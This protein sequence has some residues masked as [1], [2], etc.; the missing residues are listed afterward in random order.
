MNYQEQSVCLEGSQIQS[1]QAS[2]LAV[3]GGLHF[4]SELREAI[5]GFDAG[6]GVEGPGPPSP[7]GKV[8]GAVQTVSW[9]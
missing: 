9:V 2:L 5:G 6:L 1:R 7:I 8:T 3:A 4:S